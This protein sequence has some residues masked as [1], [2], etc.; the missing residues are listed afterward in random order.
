MNNVEER[1][2]ISRAFDQCL[3]FHLD[4]D[5]SFKQFQA[6]LET[7]SEAYERDYVENM[8]LRLHIR[9]A[10]LDR[11]LSFGAQEKKNSGR[12]SIELYNELCEY[13]FDS[14]LSQWLTLQL[15]LTLCASLNEPAREL[16]GLMQSMQEKLE[17]EQVGIAD[18]LVQLQDLKARIRSLRSHDKEN[19]NQG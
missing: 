4:S 14:T 7:L 8:P 19:R 3:I 12:S 15:V 17:S 9:R 5:S 13:G 16:D 1:R 6:S 10:R 2:K 11:L 18:S